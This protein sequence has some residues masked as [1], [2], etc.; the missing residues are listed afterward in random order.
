M[1]LRGYLLIIMA[2]ALWG[3]LGPFSKL[4]F[5][6]G[7]APMEVAFWRGLLAW[8]FFALHAGITRQVRLEKRDI[9]AIVFFGITGVTLFFGSYQMAVDKGGVALAAVLLY[10]AP[11][12]VAL[13]SGIFF[14]EKITPVKTVALVLTLVGVAGVS[15]GGAGGA[16][17]ITI[18]FPAISWGLLAGFCYA[19]YYIFG[20]HFAG[21]YTTP[22][23]FLYI[24]PIGILGLLPWVTFTPK[25]L[26]AWLALLSI[27]FLCTYIAYVVYYA[28]LKSLEATRA[29]ITATLEPVMAGVIA[30]I[31]WHEYFTV[32]GYAGSFLVLVAVLLMIRDSSVTHETS[33]R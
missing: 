3:M 9:P 1:K 6:Q 8:L 7:L 12:W 14:K 13:M 31:W 16:S 21:R 20:K 29:A 25:T 5:E 23:L 11:A 27:A 24:L 15:F 10:T 28:G 17:G 26:K 30:Y 19:L 33:G 22:N 18:D 2:A 4:A 32:W